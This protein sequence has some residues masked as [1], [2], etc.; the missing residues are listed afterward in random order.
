MRLASID[1]GTNTLRL[2]ICESHARRLKPLY[3]DRVITRLGG[4]FSQKKKLIP[5]SSIRRS[6]DAISEFSR[7]IEKYRVE[8]LRAVAT[9]VVRESANG[10]VF[11]GMVRDETGID[12]EIISATEEARFMVLGV[13]NSVVVESTRK[14]IIDIGG[15]STEFVVLN[16]DVIENIISTNLGVVHLTEQFLGDKVAVKGDLETLANFIDKSFKQNLSTE[17]LTSKKD[18]KLIATAGTPTTLAAIE[19]GLKEY[20]AGLVNGFVLNRDA[21]NRIFNR[22]IRLTA[23]E[24]LQVSG[25]EKGREDVIIPGTLILLKSMELFSTDEVIV[26]DGGLLEGIAI[27]M[28]NN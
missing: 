8:R 6:I 27:S 25:L 20:D 15:G 28:I 22:L 12:V 10:D 16:G 9:S 21:V 2:F 5:D 3:K 26:S 19:I 24:R 18:L 11:V 14:V 4:G 17:D 1:I 7:V 23:E 13:L